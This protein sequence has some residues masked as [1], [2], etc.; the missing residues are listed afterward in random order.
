ME[1]KSWAKI[2]NLNVINSSNFYYKFYDG[3]DSSQ[4]SRRKKSTIIK[5]I[6]HLKKSSSVQSNII[7]M[8]RVLVKLLLILELFLRGFGNRL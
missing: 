6:S 8:K 2:V 5:T 1:A 7:V 4:I 3:I